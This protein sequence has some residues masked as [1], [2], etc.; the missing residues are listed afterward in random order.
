[1][2]ATLSAPIGKLPPTLSLT[3]YDLLPALSPLTIFVMY[4]LEL[5]YVAFT[6]LLFFPSQLIGPSNFV[7]QNDGELHISTS[8]AGPE[9]ELDPM[10]LQSVFASFGDLRVFDVDAPAR[11]CASLNIIVTPLHLIHGTV[12]PY[13]V[14]RCPR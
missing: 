4:V 6:H 9:V 3:A 8:F 2:Y 11:V 1:M 7:N 14:F 5:I 10:A 12:F 13:R